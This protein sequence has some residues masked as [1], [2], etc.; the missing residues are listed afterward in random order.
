MRERPGLLEVRRIEMDP[1]QAV[2]LKL[3]QARARA[4]DD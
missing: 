4:I 2:S 3:G 1:G